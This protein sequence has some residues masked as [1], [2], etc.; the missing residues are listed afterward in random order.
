[1]AIGFAGVRWRWPTEANVPTALRSAWP[2]CC[3]LPSC[4][5]DAIPRGPWGLPSGAGSRAMRRRP[6]TGRC[7]WRRLCCPPVGH[8][9]VGQQTQ[10]AA[11]EDGEWMPTWPCQVGVLTAQTPREAAVDH[12][13][14]TLPD[15]CGARRRPQARTEA[16]DFVPGNATI[17]VLAPTRPTSPDW[18]TLC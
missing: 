13:L 15:R 7:L 6:P 11:Q 18:G 14:R 10:S 12:R 2:R 5:N 9:L 1:V 4:L 8:G 17:P 3:H 16:V